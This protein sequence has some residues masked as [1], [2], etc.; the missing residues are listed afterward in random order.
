[1]RVK[2]SSLFFTL[3][4]LA[5]VTSFMLRT[6]LGNVFER[7]PSGIGST[8][9]GYPAEKVFA[10][11]LIR[12][13]RINDHEIARSLPVGMF[14]PQ[15]F[16]FKRLAEMDIEEIAVLCRGA[17]GEQNSSH[18]LEEIEWAFIAKFALHVELNS[19]IER[20]NRA[21]VPG[22]PSRKFEV[23]PVKIGS[24]T[25][26]RVSAGCFF[27]NRQIESKL[28]FTK[29]DGSPGDEGVNVGDLYQDFGYIE[30]QSKASAIFELDQIDELDLVDDQ[31]ILEIYS[32]VFATHFVE[33]E[34][35]S[36]KIMLRNPIS[37]MQSL[38]ISFQPRS[39]VAQRLGISRDVR[40]REA[41]ETRSVDLLKDL[42][43][44][45][46]LEVILQGNQEGIYLGVGA[47]YLNVR[48]QAFE[49]L[50]LSKDELVVTQ[51]I[52]SMTSLLTR[53][54]AMTSE[55]FP[56][57]ADDI[58]AM[59]EV[60]DAQDR[61][62]LRSLL[63]LNNQISEASQLADSLT[64]LH[65]SL[66]TAEGLETN[67]S[68]QFNTSR[69]A[70]NFKGS[71]ERLIETGKS[72]MSQSIEQ[73]VN[74]LEAMSNL[75][76]WGFDSISFSDSDGP[77]VG[78]RIKTLQLLAEHAFAEIYLD[79][80]ERNV[81]IRF[82]A[83]EIDS[84]ADESVRF[85]LANIEEAMARDLFSRHRFATSSDMYENATQRI[86]DSPQA[87]MRRAH[88]IS[89]N[90]PPVFD[91]FD[92]RYNWARHGIGI[93]IEG[94]EKNPGSIELKCLLCT[95]IGHK[96]GRIDERHEFRRLFS[97]DHKLHRKIGTIV[98]LS[99]V[100]SP[101]YHVD[102]WLVAQRLA[103]HCLKTIED[104]ELS[105]LDLKMS[106]LL[107][108]SRPAYMQARYALAMAEAGHW[109]QSRQAWKHAGRQFDRF[110][111]SDIP[112]VSPQPTRLNDLA[113]RA[114]ELESDEETRKRLEAARDVVAIDYWIM[115]CRIEQT[116][117]MEQVRKHLFLARGDAHRSESH[118]S[119]KQYRLAI[120][121]LVEVENSYPEEFSV[122]IGDFH[123][124]KLEYK[125]LAEKRGESDTQSRSRILDLINEAEA[126]G[127]QPLFWKFISK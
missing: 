28:R 107:P 34:F 87:W 114:N 49:Y 27:P 68:L 113:D 32:N 45:G 119:F 11:C 44:D 65:A 8:I 94:I 52:A 93:L 29:R 10:T 47:Q 101:E 12:P 36:A 48:P 105:Q 77:V 122:V 53:H 83:P 97:E 3:C 74:R 79:K 98:E 57:S 51:S 13:Q 90:V 124:M 112:S 91:G 21:S 40:V 17:T 85:A 80:S 70:A 103:A 92:T 125:K 39:Y 69:K 76:S 41:G 33:D 104:N 117:S 42:V 16:S 66:S 61:E 6:G 120:D 100:A 121:A 84:F 72:S 59:I 82:Q 111:D 18:H 86:S 78:E 25:C 56:P 2:S 115:R 24:K 110:A 118:E 127:D 58:T 109:E 43:V 60:Q 62:H 123:R 89:F 67:V 71:L 38:P 35:S 75:V 102:N 99:D 31:L 88:Q 81:Q 4:G 23:I 73:S 37:G 64:G 26:F 108:F 19:I 22:E 9:L 116:D 5:C 63:K 7:Q 95:F 20:W 96:I 14:L 15:Q 126:T 50:Y 1:M 30:G 54:D 55:T 46:K 106:V